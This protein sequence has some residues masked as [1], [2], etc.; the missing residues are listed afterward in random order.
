MDIFERVKESKVSEMSH[1]EIL[2]L[3]EAVY[4]I[5]EE[6]ELNGEK[7]TIRAVHKKTGTHEWILEQFPI[8][9][10]AKSRQRLKRETERRKQILWDDSGDFR[11]MVEESILNPYSVLRKRN[12]AKSD[13][14]Q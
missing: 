2:R 6:M 9:R 3:K 1:E 8:I 11:K 4:K 10:E 13:S 7:V 12:E 14:E 5:V